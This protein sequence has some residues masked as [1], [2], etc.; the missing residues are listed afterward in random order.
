MIVLFSNLSCGH[1]LKR[2]HS[3][4]SV[5]DRIDSWYLSRN[6][7]VFL[8]LICFKLC[9][10]PICY[11]FFWWHFMGRSYVSVFSHV[12]S[13]LDGVLGV[14]FMVL[15]LDPCI[16]ILLYDISHQVLGPT[17]VETPFLLKFLEC[18]LILIASFIKRSM[19]SGALCSKKV[20]KFILALFQVY[21]L[22]LLN[23]LAGPGVCVPFVPHIWSG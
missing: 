8:F 16:S 1:I 14:F 9:T 17:E 15:P 3:N 5:L 12:S 22:P 10:S 20:L 23:S 11:A 6:C 7:F 13:Q 21:T 2:S 4:L 18:R 19:Y